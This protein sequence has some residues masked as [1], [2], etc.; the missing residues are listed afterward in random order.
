MEALERRIS[1][2]GGG[3]G[4]GGNGDNDD[5]A[6]TNA[7]NTAN[8]VHMETLDRGSHVISDPLT[9]S[10]QESQVMPNSMSDST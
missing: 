3:G 7:N 9:H 6:V 1:S 5:A 10:E 4:G 2:V 8:E